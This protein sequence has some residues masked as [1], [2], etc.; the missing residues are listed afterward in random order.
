MMKQ[1]PDLAICVEG[2]T[3]STGNAQANRTLS[4]IVPGRSWRS[5]CSRESPHRA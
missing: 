1:T 4:W 5:W 2:H 3:D